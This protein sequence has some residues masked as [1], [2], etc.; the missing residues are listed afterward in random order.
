MLEEN[1]ISY[2]QCYKNNSSTSSFPRELILLNLK[3]VLWIMLI[4]FF[5][6]IIFCHVL[7]LIEM[8]IEF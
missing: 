6:I 1:Q 7:F 2:V 4:M 3:I 5:F 8:H